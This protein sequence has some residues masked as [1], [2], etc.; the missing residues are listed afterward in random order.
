MPDIY[1]TLI[2]VSA[3]AANTTLHQTAHAPEKKNTGTFAAGERDIRGRHDVAYLIVSLRD[4]HQTPIM[5]YL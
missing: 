1:R 3:G 4:K 5:I 2:Q